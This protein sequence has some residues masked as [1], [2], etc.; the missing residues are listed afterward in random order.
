MPAGVGG[1]GFLHPLAYLACYATTPAGNPPG[2]VAITNAFHATTID[3]G[4]P[5]AV[6]VPTLAL[7]TPTP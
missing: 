7:V 5:T 3:V 2:P 4:A 6:C 1:G